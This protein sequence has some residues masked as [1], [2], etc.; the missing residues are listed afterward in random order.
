MAYKKEINIRHSSYIQINM[1]SF[2]ITK[3]KKLDQVFRETKTNISEEYLVSFNTRQTTV[4]E[5]YMYFTSATFLL[6]L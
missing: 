2:D 4:N 3:P 1:F 6:F 5:C